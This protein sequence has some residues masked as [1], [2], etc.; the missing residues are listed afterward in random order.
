[1]YPF[2]TISLN[3]I[4]LSEPK[5]GDS[6]HSIVNRYLVQVINMKDEAIVNA[7]IQTAQEEGINEITLIDKTFIIEAITEKLERERRD[8]NGELF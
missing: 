2:R 8:H 4:E 6:I 5:W 1:M 7:I 3:D